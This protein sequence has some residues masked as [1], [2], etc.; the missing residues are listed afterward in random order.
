M[1][2]AQNHLNNYLDELNK[3]DLEIYFQSIRNITS[4]I[5]STKVFGNSIPSIKTFESEENQLQLENLEKLI[6]S[7]YNHLPEKIE[8]KAPT[9]LKEFNIGSTP[10][11]IEIEEIYVSDTIPRKKFFPRLKDAISGNVDVK[12]DTVFITMK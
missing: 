2:K 3:D 9:N 7:V 6:D 8:T 4:K 5:D 11:E 12:T 1:I 10:P